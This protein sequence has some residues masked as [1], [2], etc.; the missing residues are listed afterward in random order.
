M[1]L[2]ASKHSHL[3]PTR[4][5]LLSWVKSPLW[6]GRPFVMVNLL[7]FRRD[8]SSGTTKAARQSYKT[9]T[10]MLTQNG[11]EGNNVIDGRIVMESYRCHAL[12]TPTIAADAVV[13][14]EWS[15]PENFL[16]TVS[17]PHY[18]QAH[19][20]RA[21]ALEATEMVAVQHPGAA[22]PV[23]EESKSNAF[24]TRLWMSTV[25]GAGSFP[26]TSQQIITPDGERLSDMFTNTD[27]GWQKGT[28]EPMHMINFL[29]FVR[30]DGLNAYMKYGKQAAQAVKESA[31][32][33][34]SKEGDGNGLLFPMTACATILGDTKW[35]AFAVMGYA[36][37]PAFLGLTSNKQW[38]SAEHHRER[39]L[40]KQGL[41]VACPDTIQH[42]EIERKG[43]TCPALS[44]KL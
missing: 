4:A 43:R 33:G 30:P 19:V 12:F 41:V 40:H 38:R 23:K 22:F 6:R 42:I 24:D 11:C 3:V 27:P 34:G 26:Q 39:G 21:A 2:Q 28:G 31:H 35:D 37:L 8:A 7:R 15:S 16:K 14:V 20:H 9:Y 1:S 18:M 17:T 13:M 44:A 5:R 29:Q 25:S 36:N 32:T 10:S